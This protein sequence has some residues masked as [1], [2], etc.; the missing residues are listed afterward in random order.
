MIM[1]RYGPAT[2]AR[3]AAMQNTAH[4]DHNTGSCLCHRRLREHP[5]CLTDDSENHWARTR[6]TDWNGARVMEY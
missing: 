2:R 5:D 1:K 3:I 6:T 4:T